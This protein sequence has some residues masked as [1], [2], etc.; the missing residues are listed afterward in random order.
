MTGTVPSG[1]VLSRGQMIL[2]SDYSLPPSD[3]NA[4]GEYCNM[5]FYE[6]IAVAKANKTAWA[7]GSLPKLNPA[8]E[9]DLVRYMAKGVRNFEV[10]FADWVGGKFTWQQRDG[11]FVD[12]EHAANRRGTKAI[13]F[14]FTLHDSMKII[15]NG[16]RFTH[17][18]YIGE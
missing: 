4:L 10:H 2:T 12:S 14:T 17:I 16:R 3:A 7:G 9:P 18:V 8:L 6:F 11:V 1:Q 5:S 15:K 13:K